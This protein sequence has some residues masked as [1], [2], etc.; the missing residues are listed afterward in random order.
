M[1]C[2]ELIHPFQNGPGVSQRQ[3][4]MEDLLSG[5][6]LVDGRSVADLLDYFVQ[7]SKN[8]NY[9]DD[10]LTVSDWQPFFSQSLP[11]AL[12]EII[13]LDR[14][15]LS[16]K[17]DKY[18]RL[19]SKKPSKNTMQLLM[20]CIFNNII[21]PVNNWQVKF[22]GSGLP[23][24]LRINKL[25]KDKLVSPL[26]EFIA[27]ANAS[28]KWFYTKPLNFNDLLK[29]EIW[30]LEITDIYAGLDDAPFHALGTTKKKRMLAIRSKLLDV[31]I[32]FSDAIRV[33]SNTAPADMDQSFFPLKEE[34]KK[35]HPPH[36]AILFA[37]LKLFKYLQDDLNGF[38]KKHLDFFYRDV[39]KLKV[40]GAVPDK[41]HL[42]FEI[43]ARLDKYLLKKGLLLKD[44]K[45]NNKAEV[46]FATD[47]EVV[48]N[49]AQVADQRTL[50]LN[51]L[52]YSAGTYMEGVYMAPDASKA[53]GIGKPFNDEDQPAS[54]PTLGGQ[55]SR[56][57]DPEN[58]FLKP[59]PN[60][61]LGFILASPVLLLNEGTRTVT[62]TLNCVLPDN[63]CSG[64]NPE[65]AKSDPCCEE[66]TETRNA[67]KSAGE[68][69]L[70][71]EK[72]DLIEAVSEMLNQSFYYINRDLVAAAVKKGIGKD[73]LEKLNGFLIKSP[74]EKLCYCPSEEKLYEITLPAFDAKNKAPLFTNEEL[75]VIGDIFKPGKILSVAFSGEKEWILPYNDKNVPN[76]F[77]DI[78]IVPS[79]SGADIIITA[80][81]QPD[82]K[83]VTFYNA[84]KLKEDFNTNLPLVKIELD[85]KLKLTAPEDRYVDENCCLRSS[86]YDNSNVSLYHFFRMLKVQ[87]SSKIE[88][89]VCNVKN[90]I[91]QNDENVENV[92]SLIRPFGVRPQVGANFY[93]GSR[94]VFVKNWQKVWVNVEWKDK[95]VNLETHYQ[96][97]D[98][99]DFEDGTDKIKEESFLLTHAILEN[100]IWKTQNPPPALP[101]PPSYRRLFNDPGAS[102]ASFC[103]HS[104]PLAG[105]NK[106]NYFFRRDVAPFDFVDTVYEKRRDIYDPLKPLN[107]TSRYDFL[108]L[109]L[110]GVGFQHDRYAFVVARHMFKLAHL[111]DPVEIPKLQEKIKESKDIIIA[112]EARIV[113]LR[114]SINTI[115]TGDVATAQNQISPQLTNMITLLVTHLNTAFALVGVSNS[116]AKG[117]ITL[118][119]NLVANPNQI[120]ATIAL[121]SG[122]LAN[123]DANLGNIISGIIDKDAAGDINMA[124]LGN[125][126]LTRLAKE[127]EDRILYLIVGLNADENVKLFLPKEPYTPAIKELSIDY[128]ATADINDID[129]IHLYP[130]AGTYKSESAAASPSLFPTFCDEGNLFIGLKDLQPGSNVNMLFQLA[131]ATADSESPK[132]AVQ[133]SYLENNAWKLLRP[134][135]EVLDDD[136]DGLT[137]SGIVKFALPANMTNENTILP[138]GLHWI[139]A[140]VSL[141]SKA[142]SETI[143][144]FTQAIKA[145]FTN[146]AA[147]DALRLAN[148][149]PA[150]AVAKMQ[151][152]DASVKKITQPF[153]TFGGRVPEGE[154]HFYVRAS[155]L[156]RHK[157][158]AVQKFD[159]E[160][161][162]LEAFPQIYKVK[163]I[164]HSFALDAHKYTN[165]IPLAPGYVLL[166]V[167]PDL[168]QLKAARQ[169][170]P[171]VPAGMIDDIQDYIRQRTSPFVRFKVMNPRYEKVDFCLKVK[172]Y[173][174]KDESY[175]KEKL[176]QDLREFLA[177]W[178]V[179][180]Y[181]KLSFGQCINQSDIVQFLE[182]LDYLDYITQLKMRHENDE[183]LPAEQYKV[184]P[185]SPRSV[186]IAGDI[187]VCIQQG[188]CEQW[189][190]D[191]KATPCGNTAEKTE[192][193]CND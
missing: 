173:L 35:N 54:W 63:Y 174:G 83:A 49:K 183:D 64:L 4:T 68:S 18:S 120:S 133:W 32:S 5:T 122:E 185:V 21:L 193:I 76:K 117:Q 112:I 6:A 150:G 12:T 161:L 77:L 16:G 153:D 44:G 187:D 137:T 72:K 80:I 125:Y 40:K 3:R 179:G 142:V 177:P 28:Q 46:L 7:L 66:A 41:V 17:I 14:D 94:E 123:V 140:A 103:G 71:K 39:L 170:E 36:L 96:F 93:I 192:S 45:D 149:L 58:K 176:K 171:G 113:S 73:L 82:Q 159:Y 69:G 102:A 191:P 56:Y 146:D 47:D 65:A 144:I 74:K 164:N 70:S 8:I 114:A 95:P 148:P 181:D 178:A 20:Q 67:A 48:L 151:E 50:F 55:Y 34:L 168:N 100:G 143:G 116:G 132:E 53:D 1:D 29:E 99:E 184:C 87:S 138:K 154:G 165:D 61:R 188:D 152:A 59:Y 163:C 90:L 24:E 126:G 186:L 85:D 78:Q 22:T 121:I 169:F 105:D 141:H 135:F 189:N 9:Y 79:S 111:I 62:I 43:Q 37:F 26:K 23:T 147:N 33:L 175:Y 27:Y 97:Y 101:P 98:Y 30:E 108:R 31:V 157:G 145:V 110:E 106:D 11:F 10:D 118:A 139:K 107:I 84:E 131:E 127:L 51:N 128:T 156:L 81:L 180:V 86:G 88:V 42:V 52:D 25:I 162:V 92:N 119:Q 166:A 190:L 38:T 167:I 130:Y 104:A 158:R 13:K 136:T 75:L 89:K 19:V 129:L 60:A 115:M 134:G 124:N 182:G 91:V 160:R 2:K 172:L 155:E 15:K 57:I 109:T